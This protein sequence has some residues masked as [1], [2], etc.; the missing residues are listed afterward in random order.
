MRCCRTTS[1]GPRALAA[2]LAE[3][4]HRRL[5][6]IAGPPRLTTTADRLA[7]FQ[8]GLQEAGLELAPQAVVIGDFSRDSGERAVG[9]LLGAMPG[10]TAIFACN[11]VMAVGALRALRESGLRVPDDVPSPAL[12]T[13]RS[14]AMS[15]RRSAPPRADGAH[16]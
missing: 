10:L 12:T 7:G 3:L 11:D 6:V 15:A 2:A 9:T 8:R 1:A 13:S 14:S 4:G 5:G 16:G